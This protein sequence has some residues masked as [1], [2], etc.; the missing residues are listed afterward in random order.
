MK[1]FDAITADTIKNGF[2]AT[3]LY[4][5]NADSVD[6]SKCLSIPADTDTPMEVQNE[7]E[8]CEASVNKSASRSTLIAAL[9]DEFGSELFERFE[10][11]KSGTVEETDSDKLLY[12]FWLKASISASLEGNLDEPVTRRQAM[13]V[14]MVRLNF[15][16]LI[17][18]TIVQKVLARNRLRPHCSKSQKTQQTRWLVPVA[19]VVVEVGII[20][21]RLL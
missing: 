17:T 11:I 16:R 19:E 12:R 6:Y 21:Y 2:R 10:A 14:R 7:R 18:R 8:P 5:L 3:G 20:E 9:R 13:A 4:P 15:H 1:A